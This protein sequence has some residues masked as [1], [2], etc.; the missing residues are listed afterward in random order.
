LVEVSH[1]ESLT[2]NQIDQLDAR[3]PLANTLPD[4]LVSKDIVMT[5]E[6]FTVMLWSV[7]RQLNKDT[8]RSINNAP[9][10][11]VVQWM[12]SHGIV[13]DLTA[14]LIDYN[15]ENISFDLD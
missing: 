10:H 2:K 14:Y 5:A 7:E 13:S 15:S 4:W 3:L 8:F 1:A 9:L 6:G 11:L 12:I